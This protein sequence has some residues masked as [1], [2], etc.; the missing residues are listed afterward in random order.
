MSNIVVR[1]YLSLI[2]SPILRQ[3]V[4]VQSSLEMVTTVPATVSFVSAGEFL[5]KGGRATVNVFHAGSWHAV[6]AK[7]YRG[8]QW[9]DLVDARVFVD[10]QW[11]TL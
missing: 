5:S 4:P 10:G 8:G 11:V 7:V 9:T 6:P 3:V 1:S 2:S